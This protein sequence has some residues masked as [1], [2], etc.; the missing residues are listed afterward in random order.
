MICLV[1]PFD[2]NMFSSVR[3]VINDLIYRHPVALDV[4]QIGNLK[5]RTH[6][7]EPLRGSNCT[8]AE[9]S[10][11]RSFYQH[12]RPYDSYLVSTHYDSRKIADDFT[13]P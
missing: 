5:I 1:L 6:T 7:T 10:K 3:N 9:F 8:A 4:D 11:K 13:S 2:S 12:H